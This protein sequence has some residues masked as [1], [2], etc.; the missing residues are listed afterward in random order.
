VLPV[1]SYVWR[2]VQRGVSRFIGEVTGLPIS[3]TA[4]TPATPARVVWSTYDIAQVPK[5]FISLQRL[6]AWSDGEPQSYIV[7]R[8]T[9]QTILVTEA[10][11]GEA[12]GVWLAFAGVRV[13]VGV[14][15]TIEDTRDAL[16]AALQTQLEPLE[17]ATDGTDSIIVTP[18]G[19]QIVNVTAMVGATVTTDESEYVE[20]ESITRKYRT[21]VQIYGAAGDGDESTDEYADAILMALRVPRGLIQLVQ[22]GLGVEGVPETATDISSISG[23]LQERRL[24]FDVTFV[25]SSVIYIRDVETVDE[26]E[27]P[28]VNIFDPAP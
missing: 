22:Y 11:V 23:A 18:K 12:V 13:V 8:A 17:Y 10:V 28:E 20:V 2:R 27:P 25:A 24:Y 7:E 4:G 14:G 15:A 19:T 5:P 9:Q 21:R 1:Q 6:A 16:L 3:A 26:V